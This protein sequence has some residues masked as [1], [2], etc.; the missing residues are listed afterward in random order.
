LVSLFGERPSFIALDD[1]IR[2]TV[3]WFRDTEGTTW[4]R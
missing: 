3:A 1:G 4:E 2:E